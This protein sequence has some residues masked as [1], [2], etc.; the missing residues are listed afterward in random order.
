MP[1]KYK[2][3]GS[4]SF[5]K[6]IACQDIS[7]G[8]LGITLQHALKVKDKIEV[9]LYLDGEPDPINAICKVIWCRQNENKKFRAG[10][11]FVKVKD[12]Q[13]FLVYLC[14]KIID[15]SLEAP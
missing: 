8:G 7:G 11:K 13:R 4:S 14:E 1:I 9:I 6:G 12:H 2:E 3:P 5:R 15:L 10:L